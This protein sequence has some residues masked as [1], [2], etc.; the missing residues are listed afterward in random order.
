MFK[1]KSMQIDLDKGIKGLVIHHQ[2]LT[3]IQLK[4]LI[5]IFDEIYF[6][7]PSDNRYFLEK[8]AICYAYQP[9][10][11]GV[12]IISVNGFEL[13]KQYAEEKVHAP[14]ISSDALAAAFVLSYAKD[15]FKI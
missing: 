6:T 5:L 1:D 10:E 13:L 4:R 14:E 11:K 7:P 3:E 15:S 9:L 8:G 12:R 2:P